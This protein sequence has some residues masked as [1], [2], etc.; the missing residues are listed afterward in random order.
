L[1]IFAFTVLLQG[2]F[3]GQP[4]SEFVSL[5]HLRHQDLLFPSDDRSFGFPRLPKREMQ[6]VKEVLSIFSQT[7]AG[8][9]DRSSP[10]YQSIDN[11]VFTMRK[12]PATYIFIAHNGQN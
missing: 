4:D 3:R 8:M 9:S 7:N 10:V 1:L 5:A 11:S 2:T 12:R 6:E